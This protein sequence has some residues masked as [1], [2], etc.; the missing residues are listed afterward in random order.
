MSAGCPALPKGGPFIW[1]PPT[2]CGPTQKPRDSSQLDSLSPSSVPSTQP[3]VWTGVLPPKLCERE[4][5][6]CPW[7]PGAQ[8]QQA[9]GDL[10][11]HEGWAPASPT[12]HCWD[13][14]GVGRVSLTPAG[15]AGEQGSGDR[16]KSSF[17]LCVW[18]LLSQILCE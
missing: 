10:G 6:L 13:H 18:T 5:T 4:G 11:V 9:L 12:D 2:P 17:V 7:D 3:R 16:Q 1:T 15:Q 14:A 8:H